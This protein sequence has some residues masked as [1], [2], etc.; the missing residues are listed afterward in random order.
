MSEIYGAIDGISLKPFCHL[1][2]LVL[3]V[4]RP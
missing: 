4:I 2:L 3:E 1:Q